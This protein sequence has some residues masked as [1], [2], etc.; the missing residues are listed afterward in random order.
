MR[1][2]ENESLEDT[3]L[4]QHLKG[5][6]A[7]SDVII[8]FLTMLAICHTVIPETVDGK[9][10]YHAASPGQCCLTLVAWTS[11]RESSLRIYF[12]FVFYLQ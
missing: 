9:I 8:E 6:H 1:P 2:G 5:G 3:L 7:A 11:N 10:N 4:Y 12:I